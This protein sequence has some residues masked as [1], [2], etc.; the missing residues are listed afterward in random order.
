MQAVVKITFVIGLLIVVLGACQIRITP[1]LPPNSKTTSPIS[2]TIAR[3]ATPSSGCPNKTFAQN[4]LG[5]WTFTSNRLS[6]TAK[7]SGRIMFKGDMSFEDP[8]SLFG[9]QLQNEA[10]VARLYELQG[11]TLR[12]Y[13]TDK[14]E[15]QQGIILVLQTSD[16]ERLQFAGIGKGGSVN[17]KMVR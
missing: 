17:V 11:D 13:I 5:W 14:L 8:D 10:I 1:I 2:G 16:C 12:V 3:P 6:N 4:L 15:R 9:Y 7:Y